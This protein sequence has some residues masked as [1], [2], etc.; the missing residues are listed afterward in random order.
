MD[1]LK[2]TLIYKIRGIRKKML[3]ASKQAL[4]ESGLTLEL[5]VALHF[6]YENQ[7]LTQ[8]ALADLVWTDSNVVVRMV[9]K[10]EEMALLRRV[11][12]TDDRRAYSL[13]VTEKGEQIANE[14]WQKLIEYQEE[15]LASL[16]KQ[17]R[18]DFKRYLDVVLA[19]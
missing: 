4:A 13:Y 9:D 1:Y 8:K 5:Y 11:R 16:S 12:H 18:Q 14:Y 19:E 2:N 15:C 10:L 17:E 6:A 3:M 7:G